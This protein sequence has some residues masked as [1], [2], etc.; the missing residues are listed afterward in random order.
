[1]EIYNLFKNTKLY[2]FSNQ[3]IDNEFFEI[4]IKV[5][6]NLHYKIIDLIE[7]TKINITKYPFINLRSLN[8]KEKDL[9]YIKLLDYYFDILNN[10]Q[11]T[12]EQYYKIF[13][14]IFYYFL[15]DIDKNIIQKYLM[16]NY[17]YINKIKYDKV[18]I[19]L[20]EKYLPHKRY[21]MELLNYC[22]NQDKSDELINFDHYLSKLN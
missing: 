21:L 18:F 2:L 20:F 6:K 8:R 10:T 19:K 14:L 9:Y 13:N 1:M 15:L 16:N 7:N 17:F 4:D 11:L 3:E 22:K 5:I 12:K